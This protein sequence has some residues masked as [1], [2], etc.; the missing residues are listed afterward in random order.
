MERYLKYAGQLSRSR[1]ET[2]ALTALLS[3]R[4]LPQPAWTLSVVSA[5]VTLLWDRTRRVWVSVTLGLA[6]PNPMTLSQL[7]QLSFLTDHYIPGG[8]FTSHHNKIMIH[9][10][11]SVVLMFWLICLNGPWTW[12]KHPHAGFWIIFLKI[13]YLLYFYLYWVWGVNTTSNWLTECDIMYCQADYRW[14]CGTLW[15]ISSWRCPVLT[16]CCP[17][18]G[19]S[20][21]T[22]CRKRQQLSVTG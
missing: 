2:T 5:T 15:P 1:L 22:S 9:L 12:E 7:P 20:H 3:D 4:R 21:P 19:R 11:L 14:S 8:P 16:E 10:N 6:N 13:Y 17:S 18:H